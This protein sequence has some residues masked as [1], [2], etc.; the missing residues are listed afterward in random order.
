MR[1][2]AECSKK[3]WA[4][5]VAKATRYMGFCGSYAPAW[6][7]SNPSSG[8][9]YRP[10]F[11]R[12]PGIKK[13]WMHIFTHRIFGPHTEPRTPAMV[14]AKPKRSC[15]PSTDPRSLRSPGSG[16]RCDAG[17][18]NLWLTFPPVEHPTVELRP[19]TG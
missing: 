2:A 4:G 6:S 14:D 8:P 3:P 18:T 7:V 19:S 16:E 10:G 12:M 1:C 15:A 5:V 13:S 17:P 9:D 11:R